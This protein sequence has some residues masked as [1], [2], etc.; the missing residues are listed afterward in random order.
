M[1]RYPNSEVVMAE[2]M[3]ES[4]LSDFGPGDFRDGLDVLLDSLGR[5]GDLDPAAAGRV[6]GGALRR[7]LVNRLE[8]E[9][10]YATH[11]GIEDLPVHGPVDI[12]GLP[13]TGTTALANTLS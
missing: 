1:P 8:V 10:W 4:C 12:T 2:A 5:D 11:P 3:E 9:A 6:I 7:R 13:R